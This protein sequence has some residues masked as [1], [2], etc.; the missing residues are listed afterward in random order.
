[1]NGQYYADYASIVGMMGLQVMSQ[2]RWNTVISILGTHVH[3][4][5]TRSCQ[6]VRD[7][8]ITREEKLSW[9]ASFDG[10]YLT[11]GH[12][13]NNSSATLHDIST[14]KIAW[15]THRTKRG[16]DS[17]WVGTSN[18]AEGDMLRSI[19]E[20]VKAN[21]IQI[22]QLVMDHDTSG[23]NIACDVFPEIQI[24]YY[25]SAKTFHKD[26]VNLKAIPCKVYSS[27]VSVYHETFRQSFCIYL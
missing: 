23:S 10:F 7:Q 8:I 14:D 9:K 18:G 5:A 6:Q 20:D 21:G 2:S 15:F 1:M 16:V 11:R 26:L 19:L 24:T 22:E 27:I 3:S 13:S 25:H 4:L 12:Y 17:N